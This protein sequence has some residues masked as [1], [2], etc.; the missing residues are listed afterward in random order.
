[1]S[2]EGGFKSQSNERNGEIHFTPLSSLLIMGSY[3]GQYPSLG[4]NKDPRPCGL[5]D[6]VWFTAIVLG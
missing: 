1:M 2:M 3:F 5:V 6:W 4:R